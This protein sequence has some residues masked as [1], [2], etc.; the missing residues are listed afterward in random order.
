MSEQQRATPADFSY[1]DYRDAFLTILEGAVNH[2]GLNIADEGHF[3]ALM[4]NVG[5]MAFSAERQLAKVRPQGRKMEA[6]K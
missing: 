6:V 2:N 4:D 1:G 3:R 5:L